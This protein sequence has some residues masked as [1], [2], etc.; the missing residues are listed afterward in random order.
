MTT[1][2]RDEAGNEWGKGVIVTTSKGTVWGPGHAA[3]GSIPPVTQNID[4]NT[5]EPLVEGNVIEGGTEEGIT[6][7]GFPCQ[8]P[9]CGKVAKSAAGLA[10]HARKAH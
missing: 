2:W 8:H 10:A 5:E 3:S 4:P 7:R 1:T 6:L 9:G